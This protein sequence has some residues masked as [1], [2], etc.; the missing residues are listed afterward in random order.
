MAEYTSA[1]PSGT[2]TN[3]TNMNGSSD[4]S[5]PTTAPITAS[6]EAAKTLWYV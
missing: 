2:A 1:G 4:T 6:N 5:F 3:G